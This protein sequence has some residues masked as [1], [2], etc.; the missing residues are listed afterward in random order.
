MAIS[1]SKE[2][3]KSNALAKI[4]STLALKK[5]KKVKTR[6]IRPVPLEE[7]RT[8]IFCGWEGELT[9]KTKVWG[10]VQLKGFGLSQVHA[11]LLDF[12]RLHYSY[13]K[14]DEVER[15]SMV[16]SL[17]DF[18]RMKGIQPDAKTF[19]GHMTDFLQNTITIKH[20][21]GKTRMFVIADYAGYVDEKGGDDKPIP[22]KKGKELIDTEET[23]AHNRAVVPRR[24][25]GLFE[26]RLSSEFQKFI[27]GSMF[28][29]YSELLPGLINLSNDVIKQAARFLLTHKEWNTSTDTLHDAISQQQI[30]PA[31][32]D[33]EGIKK[34][35][36]VER[37]T[38]SRRKKTLRDGSDE[39]SDLIGVV[40]NKET[41]RWD[42]KQHPLVKISA[43]LVPPSKS[44][45]E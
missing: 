27:S 24:S 21:N 20:P 41:D 36:A 22:P 38:R 5:K 31:N 7:A 32:L 1:K 29:D 43:P 42:Y 13:F 39:L 44:I 45:G 17:A 37:V 33:Q 30:M 16:I 3:A 40:Y 26:I 19:R 34:F 9:F 6:A 28:V 12:A 2:A 8:A 35:K 14:C 15:I 4:K 23:K 10:D 18:C 11:D 25:D